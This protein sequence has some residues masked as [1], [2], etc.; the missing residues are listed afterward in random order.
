[1]RAYIS[2]LV[3]GRTTCGTEHNRV[4]REYQSQSHLLRFG[5]LP[6]LQVGGDALVEVFLNWDNRYGKPDTTLHVRKTG[7][8][9]Y[10][11][12]LPERDSFRSSKLRPK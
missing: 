10:I 9:A 3:N 1:M 5:V 12:H 11:M 8:N 6:M 4:S 2:K 7:E